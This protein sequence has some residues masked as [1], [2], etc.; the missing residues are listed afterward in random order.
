MIITRFAPSPS[1][2][3]HIGGARTALYNFLFAKKFNG[4]FILRIDDTD[5]KRTEERH[6]TTIMESLRWLNIIWDEGPDTDE[7]YIQSKR[8]NIYKE[9]V[10][11][12]LHNKVAYYEDGGV[13]IKLPKLEEK[14]DWDDLIKH[15]IEFP[16]NMLKEF[17]ILK[18]D[19][20][21]TYNFA[22]VIDDILMN[23]THVIR[24]EEHISNTPKQILLYKILDEPIPKFAH[25][26]LLLGEDKTPLSK[27]HHAIGIE[28]F[29]ELGYLPEAIINYLGICG[30]SIEENKEIFSIDELREK[31]SLEKVSKASSIFSIAKLNWL[32][33]YYIRNADVERLKKAVLSYLNGI[34]INQYP[35]EYINKIILLVKDNITVLSETYEE[36]EYFFKEKEYSKEV[37]EEVEKLSGL[38]GEVIKTLDEIAVFDAEQI[39]YNLNELAKR[40]NILKKNLYLPLRAAL[41]FKL[42][43]PE[44]HKIIAILGKDVCIERLKKLCS[45]I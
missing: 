38:A 40:L 25:L 44:L 20:T 22:S 33:S 45:K 2:Y 32:N 27:R 35:S 12:L 41:T 14:I 8:L 28:E 9:Y 11:K 43:G 23:I 37:S 3:L 16:S 15:R 5:I 39:K 34:D 30:C 21:P 24:G 19:N 6:M 31:F 1:G 13:K 29:K 18:S 26:P 36:I 17:V 4:K 10:E 42:K 7:T